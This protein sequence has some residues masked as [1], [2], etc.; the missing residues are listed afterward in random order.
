MNYTRRRIRTQRVVDCLRERRF[1]PLSA[2]A[3]GANHAQFA[4]RKC[5]HYKSE[6]CAT[7]NCTY[8]GQETT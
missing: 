6:T 2:A 8:K 7:V 3:A 4:C 1:V 5:P